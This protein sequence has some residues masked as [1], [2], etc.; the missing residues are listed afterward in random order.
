MRIAVIGDI[1]GYWDERDVEAFNAS[2]VD[3]LLF[4]GDLAGVPGRGTLTV[5]ASLLQLDLP[6]ALI[7]GNHDCGSLTALGG[8]FFGRDLPA[9]LSARPVVRQWNALRD[10]L[11]DRL[12]G[13]SFLDWEGVRVVGARPWAMDG[14]RLSFR[15]ALERVFGIESLAASAEAMRRHIDS[16]PHPVIVLAHNGPHGLGDHPH[17][18]FGVDFRAGGGDN[19]DTDL[20]QALAGGDG[21]CLVVAGHMHHAWRGGKGQLRTFVSEAHGR[22]YL[23]AARVPRRRDDKAFCLLVDLDGGNPQRV[24]ERWY[25]YG[26]TSVDD[27]VLWEAPA[28]APSSR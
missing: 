23:N 13:Y 18:I 26:D 25:G 7:P 21:V 9:P 1:H 28:P 24:I 10:I 11:G 20:A 27:T 16:A 22:L 8:E 17:D 6:F 15:R 14:R 12:L 19:G 4:V 3:A 5:A 2:D